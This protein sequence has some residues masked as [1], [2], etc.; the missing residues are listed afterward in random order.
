L[1][2]TDPLLY[3]G[4]E[5]LIE[6]VYGVQTIKLPAGDLIIY[7]ATSVHRVTPVSQ[8][9]RLACFFWIQSMVRDDAQRS[10]LFDLDRSIQRLNQTGADED[11]CLWLTGSYHNLLR[12]WA[13]P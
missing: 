10:L 7:P 6:D 8:G 3:Q 9:T 2:L 1:F 13:A 4:G 12:M 5:L 11:A